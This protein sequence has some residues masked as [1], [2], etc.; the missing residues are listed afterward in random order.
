MET[1]PTAKLGSHT[2]GPGRRLVLIA[3][4]CVIESAEHTLELAERIAAVAGLR[5]FGLSGER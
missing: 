5:R 2:L 4:P 3:G 1:T